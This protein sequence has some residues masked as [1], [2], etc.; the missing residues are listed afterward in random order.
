MV[1]PIVLPVVR[2]DP[3]AA[4]DAGD[5]IR[6]MT[7]GV[8]E[9]I[10]LIDAKA[11]PT[12]PDNPDWEWFECVACYG[13]GWNP[14]AGIRDFWKSRAPRLWPHYALWAAKDI[15]RT[16]RFRWDDLRDQWRR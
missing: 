14:C 9:H 8:R 1:E 12:D 4:A 7:C 6:C 2:R 5:Y 13:P 11:P 3:P 16:I 15:W 10:D